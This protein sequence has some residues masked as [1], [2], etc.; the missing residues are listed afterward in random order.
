[1]K[2]ATLALKFFLIFSLLSFAT[3]LS[4]APAHGYRH[5]HGHG[6]QNS[7]V[8]TTVETESAPDI[9]LIEIKPA[10]KLTPDIVIVQ[11]MAD[12]VFEVLGESGREGDEEEVEGEHIGDEEGEWD[13]LDE[14]LIA[15]RKAASPEMSTLISTDDI[16]RETERVSPPNNSEGDRDR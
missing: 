3:P 16:E 15:G 13:F 5:I 1:M 12:R 14:E 10:H 2:S 6:S 11:R 7:T 9:E 8:G 4:A